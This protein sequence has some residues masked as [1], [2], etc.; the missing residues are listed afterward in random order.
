MYA[1]DMAILAPSLKALQKLLNIC[2]IYCIE[3]DIKLNAKK[4]KNLS[5]GKGPT[6]TYCL[7]LNGS[8]IEWVDKWPYLGVTLLHGP[9]FGC[10]VS[11]TLAKFYRAANSILRVDGRSDDIVMLQLLETHCVSV[12]S[13]AVEV[14]HVANKKQRSKMR[15]AYNS[16][17]RTLF[18]YSWRESVT[19]LQH[20][21]GRPTWEELVDARKTKFLTKCQRHEPGSL[22]RV[23]CS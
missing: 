16:I 21:L 8:A 15:V 10:C 5:F 22:V 9:T 23:L 14:I 13:Y 6:P 17:F 19:D 2:E 3:W 1:D 18:G 4:S 20:A 11:E 7:K 12:L